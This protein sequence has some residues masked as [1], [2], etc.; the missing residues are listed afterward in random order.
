M[1]GIDFS[2]ILVIFVIALVVLGPERLPKLAATVGRWLGRA[3][4][5]ARQFREQLEQEANRLQHE[6]KGVHDSLD[7]NAAVQRSNSQS[8][9]Y[10]GQES[11]PPNADVATEASPPADSTPA[12][13]A[14]LHPEAQAQAAHPSPTPEFG[15]HNAGAPEPPSTPAPHANAGG[16]DAAPQEPA[17]AVEAHERRA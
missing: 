5:M 1:F 7:L 10:S 15:L 9:P 4:S 6:T 11:S 12:D 14:P 3:R 8:H 16:P 13:P 17:V 2:E